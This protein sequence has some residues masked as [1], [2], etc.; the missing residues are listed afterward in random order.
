MEYAKI[1]ENSLHVMCW[2]MPTGEWGVANSAFGS[3]KYFEKN[4]DNQFFLDYQSQL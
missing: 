1:I 4:A 3:K 2:E